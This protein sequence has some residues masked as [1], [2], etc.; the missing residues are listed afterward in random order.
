[1][2]CALKLTAATALF[3]LIAGAASAQTPAAYGHWQGVLSGVAGMA[4]IE[5][6][7]GAD[8]AGHVIA[9][10]SLP[11]E[12]LIGLPMRNVKID[13]AAISFELPT[14]NQ[15]SFAGALSADGKT[16]SGMLD[17]PFG[18]ADFSLERTGEPHFALLPRNAVLAKQFVGAWSGTVQA[19]GQDVAV[20]FVLANGDGGSTGHMEIGGPGADL[21]LTITEKNGELT[22][23]VIAVGESFS[24]QIDASGQLVGNY[25]SKSGARYPLSLKE[26]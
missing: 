5:M 9:T 1:M 18:S 25:V 13:G 21:P 17:K 8:A 6:D 15:G 23:N 26:E 22:L 24:G 16:F 19:D 20:R 11:S 7:I 2:T 12:N 10:T 14:A 3:A 4:E